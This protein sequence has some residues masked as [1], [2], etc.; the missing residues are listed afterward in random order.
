MTLG[1]VTADIATQLRLPADLQG[2][3]VTDVQ[4]GS[5][6]AQNGL[7]P[8]DVIVQVNRRPAI[9]VD[10]VVAELRRVPPGGTALLLMMRGGQ[11]VF[12]TLTRPKDR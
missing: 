7:R 11:E 1:P 6:A 10:D 12:V 2:A 8:G 4:R 5:P 9:G 3:V